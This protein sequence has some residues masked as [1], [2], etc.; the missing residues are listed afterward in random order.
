E[1]R[2]KRTDS[3]THDE[4]IAVNG[5]IR[6]VR[7]NVVLIVADSA[8]RER[9]IDVSGAEREKQRAESQSKEAKAKKDTN[10]LKRAT[11]ALHRA[12]NRIKVSKHS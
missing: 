11:V 4:W 9:D 10:E 12:I 5:G 6:E 1:V 7:D 2:V 8:K 3:D